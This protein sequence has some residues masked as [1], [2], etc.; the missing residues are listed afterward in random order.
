[1]KCPG[2]VGYETGKLLREM[3]PEEFKNAL[4]EKRKRVA[5]DR[6]ANEP[7][8]KITG[9]WVPPESWHSEQK[10]IWREETERFLAVGV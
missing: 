8:V 2:Q 9:G 6:N 10:R 4:V 7:V 5:R 1:M 3:T